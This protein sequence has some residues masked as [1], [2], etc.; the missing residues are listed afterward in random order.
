MSVLEID[1]LRPI[2]AG[3]GKVIYSHPRYDITSAGYSK[4]RKGLSTI[5][6]ITDRREIMFL[7][8]DDQKD[9]DYL[10][11]QLKS[12]LIANDSENE[13]Q[14]V[15]KTVS[16]ISRGA[17]FV[18]DRDSRKITPLGET[19][20]WL[21]PELMS[22]MKTISYKSRDGLT[23]EGYLTIPRGREAKNLPI[24]INPHGGPWSRD[25]WSF[26]PETQFLASRGYAV[27]QMNFRGSTGYGRKFW[28]AS[29]KQWGRKMQDDIT[30]GVHWL[31]KE[32][33]ADPKRVCI[34]GV[35]YGGYAALAGVAFTPDLYACAVDYVGVSNLF[36]FSKTIPAYWKSWL[37][38]QNEM[39]G[40][41]VKD[42]ALL[43]A[44]SPVFFVD[45]IKAPLFVAQGANDPRV[46]KAESDQIVEAL[47]KRG[48]QVEYM[49][50]DNEGHGFSNQE[51]R[52]DFY[53]AMEAFLAKHIK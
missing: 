20:P 6:V 46:N 49:V 1:P 34:Y 52:F 29:F 28:E 17:Y 40:H 32:G 35:S 42:K 11:T 50:K 38:M 5:T 16:D 45:K 4:I 53:R 30:D 25:E 8:P 41:P 7:H 27:F 47:R 12:M 39:V 48:V 21:Q 36:T 3:A 18:F 44:A 15:V 31:T 33:Y 23:I 24:I 26:D 51:N 2:K 22:E 14:W 10:K 9:W 37:E 43:R 13:R 19:M